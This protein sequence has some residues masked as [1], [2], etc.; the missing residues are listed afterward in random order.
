MKFRESSK[1]LLFPS[2]VEDLLTRFGLKFVNSYE[3]NVIPYDNLRS[4]VC[5][6]GRVMETGGR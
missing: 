5:S 1:V 2:P 3:W 4:S 6:I